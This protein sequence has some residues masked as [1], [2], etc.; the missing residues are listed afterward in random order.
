MARIGR[1]GLGRSRNDKELFEGQ[2]GDQGVS[3]PE[4]GQVRAQVGRGLR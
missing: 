2:C 4:R 1:R 3:L